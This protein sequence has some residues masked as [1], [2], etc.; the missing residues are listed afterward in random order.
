MI[1]EALREE[2]LKYLHVQHTPADG[3]LKTAMRHVYWPDFGKD[4]E[5]KYRECS[6]CQEN[7]RL[8]CPPVKLQVQDVL[9]IKV[10]D[11][12]QCDWGQK[13]ERN[14][15][16]VVDHASIYLFAKE[17]KMKTTENSL[18]H[19]QQIIRSCGRPL[20]CITD[21]GPSYRG[22]F[23][24]GLQAMGV[25]CKHG[26]SYNP[27]SQS[28]AEK[29][30]GR[31]KK[32]IEKNPVKNPA[33]LEELV[34]GLNSVASSQLGAGSASD[35]FYGRSV[36]GMLPAA[37]GE[38]S[39]EAHQLMMDTMKKNRARLAK[40][41]RNSCDSSYKLGQKVLVWNRK[42]RKYSDKGT[43]IDME[44]GDDGFSRSFIVDLDSGN[45]V[46]LLSNH[47]L[48][49]PSAPA[50]EEGEEEVGAV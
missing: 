26:A 38:M 30:V 9:D 47:L 35:R 21:L 28:V 14:F 37:P 39:P 19:V 5:A 40:K 36:R 6:I 49:D 22:A 18:N 31:L 44:E 7:R 50:D 20:Q 16:I 32:A 24:E 29:A 45:E 27:R 8:Q 48:P 3:M 46:H 13:G 33:D 12:I 4:I 1:P 43:V 10:M 25:E 23:G 15:H 2:T 41:F 17:F 34:S 11:R 42:D